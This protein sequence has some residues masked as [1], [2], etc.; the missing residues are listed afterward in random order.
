MKSS[1]KLSLEE[2]MR[3]EKLDKEDAL[4][5]KWKLLL[6]DLKITRRNSRKRRMVVMT[7]QLLENQANYMKNMSVVPSQMSLSQMI[8]QQITTL[9]PKSLK[10]QK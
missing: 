9:T 8:A 6:P 10:N 2:R 3:L 7:A 1:K 5:A 4:I